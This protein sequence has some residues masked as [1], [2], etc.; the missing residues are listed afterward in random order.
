MM[1]HNS[2]MRGQLMVKIPDIVQK[3][4]GFND[5]KHV[6]AIEVNHDLFKLLKEDNIFHFKVNLFYYS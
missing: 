2:Q 6:E 1:Q 3:L 5:E 4:Y